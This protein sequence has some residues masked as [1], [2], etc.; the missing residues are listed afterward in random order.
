M[1][2]FD[3]IVVGGGTAGC[4]VA[5]RLSEDPARR[6]LLIEAGPDHGGLDRVPEELRGAQA[7]TFSHDWGF[8][9]EPVG[10]RVSKR[11]P[12]AR[13]LGGCSATNAMV[14]VRGAPADYDRWRDSGCDGWDWE[15][16]LPWFRRLETDHDFEDEWHGADGPLPVRRY[17]PEE[18]SAVQRF[19]LDAAWA[20]GH[21][22]V[23]DHNA[24]GAVGAGPAPVNAMAGERVSTAAAYLWPAA[25]RPNL[26]VLAERV[27]ASVDL[28]DGHAAGVVLA[29]GERLA[30]PTIVV[31][32][33][34][35]ATPAILQR[36][37]VGA[38]PLLRR[39]GID[40]KI[41]LPAV[42]ENL[43]DHPMIP[44]VWPAPPDAVGGPAFQSFVTLLPDEHGSP[45]L[46]LLP[47]SAVAALGGGGDATWS[48]AAAILKPFSRGSV[49]V[50]STDGDAPL[51]IDIGHLDDERD[52][53]LMRRA[54]DAA[55]ALG[56]A[57]PLAQIRS[58]PEHTA[59]LDVQASDFVASA[60]AAVA[61]YHHAAGTCAMGSSETSSVIAPDGVV[62]GTSG[63]YIADASVMP[64]IP[65]ANTNVPTI[66]I[67]EKIASEIAVQG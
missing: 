41:D 32:A 8:R 6:V 9:S 64:D 30:A 7:P 3:V 33:G 49:T 34:A 61:T 10:G 20:L 40:C 36:S 28:R 50:T 13:V 42:G 62:H 12:R 26:T 29:T 2:E 59:L 4:V 14:V 47:V 11:L 16:V 51:R 54:V 18:L 53:E 5:S 23:A 43:Q 15:G 17:G 63:L 22:R 21:P 35:Y 24:P 19:A 65:S 25:D 46:Q 58:G 27:V 57:E 31:T 67:A 55:R 44:L 48:I 37:G 52:I 1:A 39:L 45:T 38:R 60:R 56:S 66:M